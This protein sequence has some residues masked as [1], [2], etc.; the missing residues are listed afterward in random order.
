MARKKMGEILLEG[1]VISQDQLEQALLRQKGS[2]KPLGKILEDMQVILEEDIAK[3]LSTQFNFPYVKNFTRHRFS[4]QVLDKIDTETAL[5][6]LVFPLKVEKKTLYLAMSNPLDMSLQSD[7]AFKLAMRI[8]PCV[9]TPDEIK[10]AIKK[11]YLTEVPATQNDTSVNI[12]LVDSQEIVLH[13]AEAALKREGFTIFTAPNGAEGL[14]IASQL[15]PHLIITDVVMPRMNGIEMF[16]ALQA[17]GEIDDI[18]V[19]ALSAKTAAEDEYKL[20]EMGFFDFIAKPVNPIRLLARVKRALR[21]LE[22]K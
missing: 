10:S 16:K 4:Q 9:A 13:A 8:S 18:P 15:H 2:R 5:T 6:H 17:N 11:H 19:I 1:D 20:L 14:K 22:H 12:L 21:G 7:L 3:A